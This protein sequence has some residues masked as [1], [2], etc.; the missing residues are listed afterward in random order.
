MR[1]K[2]CD[3]SRLW[4]E[5]YNFLVC[6]RS[7]IVNPCTR[8][9]GTIAETARLDLAGSPCIQS[10]SSTAAKCTVNGSIHLLASPQLSPLE[11]GIAP[12]RRKGCETEFAGELR[13]TLSESGIT[14]AIGNESHAKVLE[15][16]HEFHIWTERERRKK[17]RS[18]F[19]TLQSML[20]EASPKADKSTIVDD[21]ICYIK[22]LEQKLQMLLRTKATRSNVSDKMQ[23][24]RAVLSSLHLKTDDCSDKGMLNGS[25]FSFASKASVFQT[26]YLPNVV[27]NICGVDAFVNVCTTSREGLL[28]KI[29]SS[30]VDRHNLE[31]VNVQ[32]SSGINNKRL[33]MIHAQVTLTK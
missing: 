2:S 3:A 14:S 21:A 19:V 8:K 4:G 9:S 13:R 25:F 20:P 27:L 17:M 11:T 31:V 24:S 1:S 30:V 29:F 33:F 32:I 18:M 15:Q 7:A 6:S 16:D 5:S 12:S 28:S 10:G 26:W 23:A 22:L